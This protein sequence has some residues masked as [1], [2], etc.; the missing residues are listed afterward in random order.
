MPPGS[1]PDD[2]SSAPLPPACRRAYAALLEKKVDDETRAHVAACAECGVLESLLL[3][4]R[5]ATPP[6]PSG[7]GSRS[8][9]GALAGPLG[10]EL[11][12]AFQ[13][14]IDNREPLLGK[15]RLEERVAGGGQGV[16]YRAVDTDNG[17][18]VAI[19]A[20]HCDPDDPSSGIEDLHGRNVHHT[21]IVA[22]YTAERH[23]GLRLIVMEFVAETLAKAKG[24]LSDREK[25]AVFRAVCDGVA[26]AHDADILHLDLKPGN[27]L[28]R[29]GNQPA[30]TDFGLSVRVA[31][32]PSPR[33]PGYTASYAAPEQ[34]D[35]RPVSRR[36][37]V[38]ALGRLLETLLPDPP[39]TI[40]RAI[41]RAT[42]ADPE[43]RY[44]DARALSAAI[45]LAAIR[46]RR[47]V[48]TSI[49]VGAVTLLSAVAYAA[50]PPPMGDRITW[51]SE[52]W[53][54]DL[55]PRLARTVA[56]NRG[57]KLPSMEPDAP[58]FGCARNA[59]ELNDGVAHYRDMCHGWA[60]RGP[61]PV[62]VPDEWLREF[63][64][65]GGDPVADYAPCPDGSA[66]K[67]VP[68]NDCEKPEGDGVVITLARP[69]RIVAVRS[70]YHQGVPSRMSVQIDDGK[71]GWQTVA[72]PRQVPEAFWEMK[73]PLY[74]AGGA[75]SATTLLPR[76]VRAQR[77][78]FVTW[79]DSEGPS[80]TAGEPAWLTEIE[81]FTDQT[82]AQAWWSWFHDRAGD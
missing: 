79:C 22:V 43:A 80:G 77:L 11:E 45:D 48:R 76:G 21:N 46:R 13:A 24:R 27:V 1:A 38:Y 35:G 72:R 40:K 66:R 62:C 78:R 81:L 18:T 47:M 28:L 36:T 16:V 55:V 30:V 57:G 71:G 9:L 25:L 10:P 50:I 63:G 3:G 31:G 26:A 32:D 70:W 8:P 41:R 19:K 69:E 15:Y 56:V 53:G 37:D 23:G 5:A 29:P 20:V 44:R 65:P 51:S 64:P 52:L 82:R 7:S 12:R 33:A 4:S 2:A 58:S 61:K 14:L 49:A 17:Q 34:R 73:T 68:A 42:A 39:S 6:P 74:Y 59:A 67:V 60:F 54:P 75:M